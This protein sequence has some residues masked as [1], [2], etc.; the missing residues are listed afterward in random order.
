MTS[1]TVPSTLNAGEATTGTVDQGRRLFF[2]FAFPS[3]GLTIRLSALSGRVVCFASDRL[4]NPTGTQGYDWRIETDDYTDVFI[5]PILL[6]RDPGEYIYISIEGLHVTNTFSLNT[7]LGDHRGIHSLIHKSKLVC[8][9]FTFF[10][11]F[12][13]MHL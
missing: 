5:D 6:N 13:L 4:T 3:N 9:T 12:H 2:R 1:L 10:L 11:Q 8:S 7:T